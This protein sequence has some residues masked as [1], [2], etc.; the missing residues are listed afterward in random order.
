MPFLLLPVFCLMDNL[1]LLLCQFLNWTLFPFSLKQTHSTQLFC[2]AHEKPLR[3]GWMLERSGG[4]HVVSSMFSPKGTVGVFREQAFLKVRST[5]EKCSL[6]INTRCCENSGAQTQSVSTNQQ[7]LRESRERVG[8]WHRGKDWTETGTGASV[9]KRIASPVLQCCSLSFPA[10]LKICGSEIGP[11]VISVSQMRK[12]GISKRGNLSTLSL[13]ITKQYSW[14]GTGDQQWDV[15][16]K[17]SQ[18]QPHWDQW[19]H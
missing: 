12:L 7:T 17:T 8:F 15:V 16:L 14:M 2:N 5:L 11:P 1:L 10:S 9:T 3:D 4:G 18:A 13:T 6:P 19:P